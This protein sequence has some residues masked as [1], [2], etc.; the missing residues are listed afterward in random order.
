MNLT[1]SASK[2][3]KGIVQQYMAQFEEKNS[4][5]KHLFPFTVL[6]KNNCLNKSKFSSGFATFKHF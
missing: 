4:F 1:Q 6:I 2:Q 5:C 3:Q